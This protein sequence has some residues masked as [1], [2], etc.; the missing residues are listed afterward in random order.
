MRKFFDSKL[1]RILSAPFR[2]LWWLITLPYNSIRSAFQFLTEE[3]ESHSYDEILVSLVQD[4]NSREDMIENIEQFRKHLLR[5]V[6]YLV[7]GV[8][9]AFAFN[10]KLIAFIAQPVG[11][12][13]A[14]KAIEVTESI[15]VFMRVAL[16]AGTAM[17]MIPILY[18]FWLF[19]APGLHPMEKI[20]SLIAIP[21]AAIFFIGG[22]AFAFYVILPNALPILLNFIGI[23]T[24][25]RPNSYFSF[26]TGLMF[27]MGL[28]FEFPI[29]IVALTMI[30]VVKPKFLKDQWR[31][32]IIIIAV[33][34][35]VITPT[36]DPVNMALV[37]GPTVGLYFISVIL[38]YLV[39]FL[40]D[41]F[42]KKEDTSSSEAG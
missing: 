8:I 10:Q 7:L 6:L 16:M 37:M 42:S 24:E 12:L 9:I 29:L 11:G 5:S 18:E 13:E 27:W 32:A 41:R 31:L 35:A 33:L 34:A 14:L 3:P 38:S 17:A 26:A 23:A 22:M 4:S 21:A 39:V 20:S 40:Q 2:G 15:G 25:L 30:R 36:V 28:M 19:A 1:G